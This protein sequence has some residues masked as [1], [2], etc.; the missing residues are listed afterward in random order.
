MN[1][2][3]AWVRSKS[4]TTH[5]IGL[6]IAGF[7]VTYDSSPQLQ[8][9]IG[10]LFTGYPVIVTHL[11]ILC[12]NIAAGLTI[13]RNY[14]HGLSDAGAVAYGKAIL[15]KPDAPTPTQVEAATTTK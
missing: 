7:A 12:A 14:S 10:T 13:W 1:N 6:A 9:Y 2:F 5:A 15:N 4:K 3:I 8:N 11:G